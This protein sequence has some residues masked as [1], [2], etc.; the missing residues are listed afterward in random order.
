MLKTKRI[1][2]RRQ[3]KVLMKLKILDVAHCAGIING[4]MQH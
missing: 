4:Q 3:L 2:I 1:K